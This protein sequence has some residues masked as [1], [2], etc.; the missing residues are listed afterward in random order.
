MQEEPFKDDYQEYL[1]WCETYEV[2]DDG[3][4]TDFMILMFWWVPCVP[5]LMFVHWMGW[6]T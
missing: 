4:S 2:P 1:E 6:I 5:V 3:Q